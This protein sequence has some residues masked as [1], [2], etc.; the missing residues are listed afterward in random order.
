MCGTLIK[1]QA[2]DKNKRNERAP[3]QNPRIHLFKRVI[4]KLTESTTTKEILKMTNTTCIEREKDRN[5]EG[6]R[7]RGGGGGNSKELWKQNKT[8]EK[9]DA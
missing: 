4:K 7:G 2:N 1:S 8:K 5:E 3:K 9:Y 6:V